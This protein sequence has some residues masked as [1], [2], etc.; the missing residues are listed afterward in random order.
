MASD[1]AARFK[2][3]EHEGWERI[4]GEYDGAFGGLTT[5]AVPALL[6]AVGVECGVRLLD[7]CTGPGYAAGAAAERG[8]LVTGVDF[9]ERMVG[10]ASRR[11]PDV[12]FR[13]AD[14]EALPFPDASFDSVVINYGILHLARP[15]D[16]L[17]ECFRVLTPGGRVAVTVWADPERALGFKVVLGAVRK[18]GNMNVDLPPAPDFFHFSDEAR[19]R[20]SFKGAGFAEIKIEEVP[21]TWTVSAP[22]DVFETMAGSTVRT[23]GLLKAQTETARAAIRDATAEGV[24]EFIRDGKYEIPMP[25]VLT[26]ARK[27]AS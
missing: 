18:L 6:D 19:S 27:P 20:K 3:F 4:P 8:G 9:S 16:C 25:A 11:W 17:S 13:E 10:I 26:A 2:A 22:G 24:A 21:Q 1:G 15:E 12:T 5:Q 7:I 14:A 23:A